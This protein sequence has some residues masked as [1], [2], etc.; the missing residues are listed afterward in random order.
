MGTI[1]LIASKV[2]VKPGVQSMKQTEGRL[3][4]LFFLYKHSETN[5]KT[6]SPCY[7]KEATYDVNHASQRR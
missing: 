6:F 2:K 5:K 7:S 3:E 1:W 4:L